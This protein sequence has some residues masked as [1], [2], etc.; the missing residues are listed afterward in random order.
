VQ[1]PDLRLEFITGIAPVSMA[2]GDADLAIRLVRPDRGEVTVRQIGTMLSTL[3]ASTSYLD[4]NPS[5][6]AAPLKVARLIGWGETHAHLPA[7]RWLAARINRRP[8]MT[9]TTLAAQQAAT[10]AGL[11]VGFCLVS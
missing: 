3:Y 10:T 9:F 1:H 4:R 2:R 8:D 11:G 6:R 5:T 7:A